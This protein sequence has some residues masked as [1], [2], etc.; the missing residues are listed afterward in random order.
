MNRLKATN[1]LNYVLQTVRNK[2]KKLGHYQ[3]HKV[4]MDTQIIFLINNVSELYTITIK[5][6]Y[7]KE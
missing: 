3:G 1:K 4:R 5:E 2:N 6:K 7:I